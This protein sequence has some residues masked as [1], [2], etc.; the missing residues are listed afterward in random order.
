MKKDKK[1]G[2][3]VLGL[4]V[5]LALWFGR[6]RTKAGDPIFLL[7]EGE[8]GTKIAPTE[9]ETVN[10]VSTDLSRNRIEFVGPFQVQYGQAIAGNKNKIGSRFVN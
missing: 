5:G 7:D 6:K 2:L 9:A 8:F 3:L 1:N 4:V 10:T